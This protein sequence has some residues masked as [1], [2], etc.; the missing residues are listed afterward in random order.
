[1]VDLNPLYWNRIRLFWFEWKKKIHYQR[2]FVR[3]K[4]ISMSSPLKINNI[5]PVAQVLCE[6][7]KELRKDKGW[8]LENF[9]AVSGVSRSMLSQIERGQANPTLAV[10]CK[11]AQAFS[12]SVGELVNE[13]WT[14]SAIEV[15][16]R[17][18]PAF[19][20]RN[21]RDCK[22]RT[23]SPLNMEKSIE[24]YELSINYKS[25]LKSAAHFEGAR[26]FITVEKGSVEITAGIDVSELQQGDSAHYRGDVEH[27][28]KNIGSC[29][30]VCF[31]VVSY[32]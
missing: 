20:Y 22:I 10:A 14:A 5:E 6:K 7:V 27:N 1:L 8:T 25:Q 9:A 30:A 31:L 24:F 12:I 11:I 23:L 13:P 21:D 17:D 4:G 18:D 29:E 26:E 2:I 3:I 15:I 16:R 19:L 32:S 28:I